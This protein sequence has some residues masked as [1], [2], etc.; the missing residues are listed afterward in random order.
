MAA[1]CISKEKGRA[2]GHCNFSQLIRGFDVAG[3]ENQTPVEVFAPYLR[4]LR[5]IRCS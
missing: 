5:A 3:D 1:L 2:Q 4:L